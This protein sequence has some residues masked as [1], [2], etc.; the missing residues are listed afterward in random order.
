MKLFLSILLLSS[1]LFMFG[2]TFNDN[3]FIIDS[4]D[5]KNIKLYAN[6]KEQRYFLYLNDK[7]K[8]LLGVDLLDG[9][10]YLDYTSYM[11]VFKDFDNHFEYPMLVKSYHSSERELEVRYNDPPRKYIA[12]LIRGNY[13][14]HLTISC[15]GPKPYPFKDKKAFYLIFVPWW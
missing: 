15:H 4:I 10:R 9:M 1:S 7:E 12:L 5:S 2:Q 13:Y 11:K 14:N 8:Y 6:L 3:F